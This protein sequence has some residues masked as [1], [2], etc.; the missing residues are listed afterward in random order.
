MNKILNIEI[1]Q[2][3]YLLNNG[4]ISIVSDDIHNNSIRSIVIIIIIAECYCTQCM[5]VFSLINIISIVYMYILVH[6]QSRFLPFS[7]IVK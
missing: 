5:C 1:Y 2:K 6:L 7:H 3:K 4:V